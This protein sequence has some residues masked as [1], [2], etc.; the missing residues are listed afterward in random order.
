MDIA[1]LFVG[2]LMVLPLALVPWVVTQTDV[3]RSAVMALHLTWEREQR[4][5]APNGVPFNHRQNRQAK[6]EEMV[7]SRPV[8]LLWLQVAI[9]IAAITYGL[10]LAWRMDELGWIGLWLVLP[11]GLAA[12]A[13]SAYSWLLLN[14]ASSKLAAIST[15]LYGPAPPRVKVKT[16]QV[17]ESEPHG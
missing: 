11:F 12:I 14:G 9:T 2:I 15:T 3:W 4:Q 1:R 10:I 7:T 6:F 5:A 8:R 13:G 17:Q 16:I